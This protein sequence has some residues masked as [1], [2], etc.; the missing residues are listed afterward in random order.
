MNKQTTY[1][2]TAVTLIIHVLAIS[3]AFNILVVVFEF[4]DILRA[5]AEYRLTLFAEN[6]G[7]VIPTYY[8]LAL[9]GLTQVLLSVLLYESFTEKNGLVRTT[10]VFGVLT[11]VFQVLG[12][13]RWPI[14]VPYFVEAMNSGLSLE[15]IAFVE[16]MM[17]RYAGMALGEHLGFL[18][19][20]IW[21]ALLGMSMIKQD[22]FDNRLGWIG[23][24]IGLVTLPMSMEPLGGALAVFGELTWPVMGAWLIWLVLIA[25][26]LLRTKA[27]TVTNWRV[28]WKVAAVATVVWAILV[29][30]T[31]FG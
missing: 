14:V 22:L 6:S 20:G 3:I 25:V 2:A 16:G 24:V 4:P 27:E 31:Y 9:T 19:Q 21:T 29:V 12:F 10:A 13:I 30:P 18:C 1:Q 23:L 8:V 5:S 26:S 28:S 15:T 17:N 7:I 11:G